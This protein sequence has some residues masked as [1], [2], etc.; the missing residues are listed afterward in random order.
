MSDK[1][2]DDIDIP[3][4]GR[5]LINEEERVGPEYESDFI[6]PSINQSM[7]KMKPH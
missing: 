7:N 6:E 1:E 3:D 5:N 2:I 4:T